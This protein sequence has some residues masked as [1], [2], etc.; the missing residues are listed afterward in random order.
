LAK[1]SKQR[2]D[3]LDG[4]GKRGRWRGEVHNVPA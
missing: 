1:F 4:V 3:A 2:L